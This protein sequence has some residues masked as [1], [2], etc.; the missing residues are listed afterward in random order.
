[1]KLS[2]VLKSVPDAAQDRPGDPDIGS[3][4]Y[5]SQE[6]NPG[7]LFVAVK[8]FSADGHDYI[9]DATARGAAVV[10]AQKPVKTDAILIQTKNTRKALASVSSAFYGHPSESLYLIGI[11]GTNGK[12]T[13]TYLI[14]GILAEAGLNV[15]IIGTINYR[16]AGKSFGN[17]VTTPESLDLQRILADMKTAGMSH[18]VMEVSSH[19][20]DL[21]RVHACQFNAGVFI[22]LSQDHLDYHQT[23]D[24]YWSCK[25][26]LF[27]EIL[28]T[29]PKRKRA[30]AAVNADDKRGRA[31]LKHLSMPVLSFG[32]AP[33]NAV[34]AEVVRPSPEGTSGL[35]STPAGAFEF[36]SPLVGGHNIENL[37]AAAS[38]GVGLQIPTGTIKKGIESV[39]FIPGRLQPVENK[40]G[41]HV[42]VDYAHT[43]EALEKALASLASL[44]SGRLICVF[45]C[46]GDRDKGKR[47]LMGEIAAKQCDLTVVTSD[48]PRSEPPLE[49]IEQV[50]RGV[51]KLPVR[52]YERSELS[53]GFKAK[54]FIVESDRQQAIRLAVSASH[55]GDTV[56]VAGKGHET[57]Q[58]I[59]RDKLPFNDTVE[60]AAALE[61]YAGID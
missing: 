28:A 43:P 58:I 47:P 7:G 21:F 15:G 6:V 59:G 52:Q 49:I 34:R 56:L 53:N 37:L 54:G 40:A 18:V 27:T 36:Q 57:V 14:E 3:I 24:H 50:V 19:G 4:H 46:G 2:K 55:R 22:N 1:M 48:N 29:G 45:G 35:I 10:L 51:Q 16:Y 42:Y 23:M 61:A 41:R 17:P 30:F 8:G 25:K 12:T 20:I 38:V 60:A 31:L 33:E 13:T 5:R 11:T 44:S 32:V 39:R 9:D 26:K